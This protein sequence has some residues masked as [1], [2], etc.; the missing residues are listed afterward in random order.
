MKQQLCDIMFGVIFI[1]LFSF[2]KEIVWKTLQL[3]MYKVY[4]YFLFN[5]HF[6]III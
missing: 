5:I 6:S 1:F 3:L 4:T 2:R